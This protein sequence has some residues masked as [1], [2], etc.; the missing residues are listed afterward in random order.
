M[1]P[2]PTGWDLKPPVITAIPAAASKV[3]II[4]WAR[5]QEKALSNWAAAKKKSLNTDRQDAA[6]QIADTIRAQ[7]DAIADMRVAALKA[8]R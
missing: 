3:T 2:I 1:S 6:Y 5:A 4:D 7:K 8:I